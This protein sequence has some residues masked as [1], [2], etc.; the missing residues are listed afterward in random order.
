MQIIKDISRGNT[1]DQKSFGTTAASAFGSITHRQYRAAV[2]DKAQLMI[3]PK[4]RFPKDLEIM[5][6]LRRGPKGF[7]R[8]DEVTPETIVVLP[9]WLA[10]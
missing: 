10:V 1:T 2:G 8:R 3:S 5:T 4:R 9:K 6:A 7:D